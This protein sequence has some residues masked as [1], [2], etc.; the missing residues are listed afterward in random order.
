MKKEIHPIVSSEIIRPF[1]NCLPFA[2]LLSQK[3]EPSALRIHCVLVAL[4][5][6]ESRGNRTKTGQFVG[7]R[8]VMKSAIAKSFYEFMT[9]LRSSGSPSGLHYRE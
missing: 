7:I 8:D 1:Y 5:L 4:K 9:L 6:F 2:E 3:K